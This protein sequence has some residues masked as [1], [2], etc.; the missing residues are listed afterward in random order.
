VA[1]ETEHHS[2]WLAGDASLSTVLEPLQLTLDDEIQDDLDFGAWVESL[3]TQA[4]A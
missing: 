3:P 2:L 1:T 4:A